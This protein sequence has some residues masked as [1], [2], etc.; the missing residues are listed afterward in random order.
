MKEGGVLEH[1]THEITIRR[2]PTAIPESIPADVSGMAIGDTL[3]L[4]AISAP[5]GVEFAL[6][7]GVTPTRSRSPRS[8]RRESRRSPSRSS[9]RRPS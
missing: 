5:E 7:E 1:V 3:Q 9:R 6:G 2:C 4:S 8:R